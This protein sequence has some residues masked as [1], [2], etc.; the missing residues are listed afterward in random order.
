M[1]AKRASLFFSFRAL[2]G[3]IAP[4]AVKITDRTAALAQ[5]LVF[6]SPPSAWGVVLD[7]ESAGGGRRP[8]SLLVGRAQCRGRRLGPLASG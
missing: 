2:A 1:R 5:L 6:G 4:R 3:R 8:V 7:Q